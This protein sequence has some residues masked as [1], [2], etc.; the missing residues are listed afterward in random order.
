MRTD[1]D[2]ERRA[3][4]LFKQTLD[5]PSDQ[6]EAF[7]NGQSPDDQTMGLVRSLLAHYQRAGE[8]FL[9]G[10]GGGAGTPDV[11]QHEPQEPPQHVGPYVLLRVIGQ[12]GMGVVY[13][14]EEPRLQR[15][16]ALKLMRPGLL[17]PPMRRRFEHEASLLARLDH[18]GI[19]RIYHADVFDAGHGPQ[20][21]FAMELVEGVRLDEYLAAHRSGLR[22]RQLVKTFHQVCEAVQHAHAKGVVHRD[23]KPSNILIARDGNPKVLDFGVA[24]ATDADVQATTLHTEPGQLVGTLPYM[25]P[26]QAAGKASELDAAC[27]VYALGVIAYEL[28][29]GRLPYAV[30]D[31]ALHE[32]VRIICEDE[33]SRL[34]SIDRSLRGDVETI[35]RKAMDKDRTRRYSTAGELAADVKRYLDYEPITARPPGTWYQLTKFGR[36]NKLLVGGVAAVMIVTGAGAAAS[37]YFAITATRQRTEAQRAQKQSESV[38]KFVSDSLQSSDPIAGGAQG[39]TVLQAMQNALQQVRAGAFADDPQTDAHLRNTIAL[40]LQHNG[41]PDQAE[42]LFQQALEM[43]RRQHGGDHVEVARCLNN[44]ALARGELGQPHAAEVLLV[45]SLEMHRRLF[46]G[47][48]Q[49]VAMS[50][51][52][53][54]LVR[55]TLGQTEAAERLYRQSLEMNQRLHPGDHPDV[56]RDLNNLALAR[57]DLGR[58]HEAEPLHQQALEMNRR[59][60]KGDH[61]RVA[62]ALSNLALARQALGRADQAEALFQQALEMNRRLY[63]GDHRAVATSLDNLAAVRQALGRSDQ[64]EPL[65]EEAL[66]MYQRL[67]KGDHPDIA[68]SLDNLAALR[69]TLGRPEEAEPLH[70]QALEMFRR[71]YKGDHPS[72]AVS[73][74]NVATAR[75]A[76]RQAEHA[77]PLHQQSLEMFQRLYKGDHPD[78]VQG[79]DNLA[80]ARWRLG[81]AEQAEALARQAVGMAMR[82]PTLGPR[83][84]LTVRSAR[85]HARCLDALGRPAD[86]TAVREQFGLPAPATRPA[87]S[88]QPGEPQ[89]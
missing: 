31:V 35:V 25:S 29:S 36:R 60:H 2:R 53:L 41:R 18:P 13:E 80:R 46:A 69:Q 88:T 56:A 6:R 61:P 83:H 32:A 20:P 75:E 64:A 19:A 79:L 57:R 44:L 34:S 84:P 37:T 51:S 24:R 9:G 1:S 45:E 66:A 86:A 14:A 4:E 23:L 15:R 70:R 12:G 48:H 39:T 67:Y 76:L 47:D 65:C 73:L 10:G 81:R 85:T 54:G 16:V 17:S 43:R 71:V 22:L 38:L 27:D 8:Q 21:Y 78:V 72:V 58:P 49:L 82:I 89:R 40:I 3:E 42:L 74:S 55:Q 11:Q 28:F 62:I 59:L 5:L 63:G 52:N 30:T 87:T 68:M 77:E 33:P 26:E 7:L 50:L